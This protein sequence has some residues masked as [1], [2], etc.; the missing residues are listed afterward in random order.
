SSMCLSLVSK[1]PWFPACSPGGPH[2][3]SMRSASCTTSLIL[4]L[5]GASPDFARSPPSLVS[6]PITLYHSAT[7]S[8]LLGGCPPPVG[9]WVFGASRDATG[10]RDCCVPPAPSI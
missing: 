9:V 6:W 3:Y 7:F 5:G 2:A 10:P 8:S 1:F 4:A